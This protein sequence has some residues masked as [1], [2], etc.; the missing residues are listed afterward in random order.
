MN[1]NNINCLV[2][3]GIISNEDAERMITLFTAT[4]GNE[5]MISLL[6]ST[7]S[8][9]ANP[10]ALITRPANTTAYA[11]GDLVSSTTSNYLEFDARKHNNGSVMIRGASITSN[12]TSVVNASY[13]IHLLLP[14]ASLA[15]GVADNA[16]LSGMAFP[17]LDHLGYIDV[18]MERSFANGS[19]GYGK[20]TVRPEIN[21]S[22][23]GSTSTKIFG[24]LEARATRTPVSAEQLSITLDAIRN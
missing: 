4:D 6:L 12:S 1:I 24:F 5:A 14:Q 9:I 22:G 8:C 20:V 2:E 13:R 10:T 15:I 21:I 18:V 16:A 11:I 3:K 23:V 17:V 7:Q 19:V